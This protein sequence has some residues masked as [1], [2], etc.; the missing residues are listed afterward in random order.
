M[1]SSLLHEMD[2]MII[3]SFKS[4]WFKRHYFRYMMSG[5]KNFG[6]TKDH[7]ASLDRCGNK[8][9]CSFKNSNTSPFGPCQCPGDIKAVF[10]KKFVQIVS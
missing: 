8:F 9:D 4:D 1:K 10:G 6:I 2:Q 5:I 7:Q 3:H